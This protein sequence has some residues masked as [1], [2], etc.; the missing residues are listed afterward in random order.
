[1]NKLFKLILPVMLFCGMLGACKK[2]MEQAVLVPPSKIEGFS[3]TNSQLV[4]TSA[5][6]DSKVI[7]FKFKEPDF[8]SKVVATYTLQFDAPSDTS[9]ANAWGNAVEV[10]LAPDSTQKT[11]LG[12]DFN[13]LVATQL[14]FPTGV[15]SKLA[16][17]LK[18][19]INQTSG[20]ATSVKPVYAT[21]TVAVNPYKA[22]VVYPALVVKG[23][24]SWITPA[25]AD[26]ADGYVLTSVGFNTKYEGYLNLPN[27]DGWSGDAFKLISSTDGKEYGWGTSAT[28]LS[29]GGGNLWLTPSPNY[30]K[31]N[32]DLSAMTI[33]YT[34]AKFYISGDDN[35]WS[36]SATPM[37]Y[38]ATNKVWKATN[39]AL[40]AGKALVFTCNGGYDISY[41]VNAEGKLVFAGAPTWAGTNIIASKTGVFT[42]TLDLSKGDGNYSYSIK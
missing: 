10:I 40:T 22:L 24:N 6:D 4:L 25:V 16:V 39:V 21:L 31:V 15:E 36:T 33:N 30:M 27:A 26:R 9:G 7:T 42:V 35:G 37:T 19:E 1:M 38:D 2:D 29:V 13:A 12:K 34:P 32:V 8:G 3:V 11:F 23:G 28:T 20:E 18:A 17:R 5:T 41:K 14:G